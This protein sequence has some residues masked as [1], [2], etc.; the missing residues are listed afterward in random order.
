MVVP[1]FDDSLVATCNNAFLARHY[2]GTTGEYDTSA[3]SRSAV[4][5]WTDR[6]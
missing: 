6:G 5:I 3:L 4:D 2:E 1:L